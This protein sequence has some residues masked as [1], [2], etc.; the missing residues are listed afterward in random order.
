M[1]DLSR[2][3]IFNEDGIIG[4]FIEKP[5]EPTSDW[6]LIGVY[7]FNDKIFEALKYVNPS[8]RR[9]WRTQTPSRPSSTQAP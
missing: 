5:K 1:T 9:N 8:W 2:S 7:I 4:K 6:A 3:Y